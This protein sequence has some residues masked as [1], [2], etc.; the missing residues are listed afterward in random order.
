MSVF[1]ARYNNDTAGSPAYDPF[2]L[3]KTILAAYARGHTSSRQIERLCRENIV[4][5]M[6][7]VFRNNLPIAII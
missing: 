4:F 7:V 2:L 3:L 1:A 5:R 6:Q